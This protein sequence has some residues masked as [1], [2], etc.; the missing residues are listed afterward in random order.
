MVVRMS[1]YG[2]ELV[3]DEVEVRES[4][5]EALGERRDGGGACVDDEG[6][7]R[8][9]EAGDGGGIVAAPGGGVTLGEAG[10]GQV[11]IARY[12]RKRS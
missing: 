12:D 3:D 2:D 7:G 5:H 4:R 6:S 11:S 1:V 8:G 9:E 10:H